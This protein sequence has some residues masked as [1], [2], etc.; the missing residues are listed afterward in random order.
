MAE[1]TRF[2]K[3]ICRGLLRGCAAAVV[4]GFQ[5]FRE[6]GVLVAGIAMMRRP[7][8]GTR[9]GLGELQGIALWVCACDSSRHK[10]LSVATVAVADRETFRR[11]SP[12]V[13]SLALQQRRVNF[14]QF[15]QP[16]LNHPCLVRLGQ[17][18]QGF[19]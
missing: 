18:V 14:N 12:P 11:L 16:V 6:V 5:G 10:G 8:R 19:L 2:E 3:R 15:A 13:S 17:N 9:L 7:R 4:Q 1:S